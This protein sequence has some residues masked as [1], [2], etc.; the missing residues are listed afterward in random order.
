MY[1]DKGG[2]STPDTNLRYEVRFSVEEFFGGTA[3][4]ED[5]CAKA[6]T[7]S[8]NAA[9]VSWSKDKKK[10]QIYID[11]LFEILTDTENNVTRIIPKGDDISANN[12]LTL[13]SCGEE[14]DCV[15]FKMVI[16]FDSQSSTITGKADKDGGFV[17]VAFT[18]DLGDAVVQQGID[19]S[20]TLTKGR[21]KIDGV[22]TGWASTTDDERFM[23]F[24]DDFN[25]Y[26][27]IDG[28][29]INLNAG[30]GEFG[31]AQFPDSDFDDL[32]GDDNGF[33]ENGLFI[34]HHQLINQVTN[35]G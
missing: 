16:E 28:N 23:N 14:T 29:E 27:D 2:D 20:G 15:T 31:A 22:I 1:K 11:D 12:H 5:V 4:E 7:A 3:T 25:T 8:E 18:S 19:G 26:L 30:D 10:I 6:E 34:C 9:V 35:S 24:G 17:Q 33:D 13:K 32:F 21:Y